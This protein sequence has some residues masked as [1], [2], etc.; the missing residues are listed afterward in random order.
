MDRQIDRKSW[1]LGI[2]NFREEIYYF[3]EDIVYTSFQCVRSSFSVKCL[4]EYY[5]LNHW[6]ASKTMTVALNCYNASHYPDN[7]LT[8]ILQDNWNWSFHIKWMRTKF[9]RVQF[10]KK[11]SAWTYQSLLFINKKLLR[12]KLLYIE[13]DWWDYFT[14]ENVGVFP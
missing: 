4:Q 9:I 12:W 1:S 13:F 3:S 7:V 5:Q 10:Y 11:K 14:V 6:L 8:S 2:M